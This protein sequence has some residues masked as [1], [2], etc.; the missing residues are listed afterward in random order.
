MVI[1]LL[2]FYTIIRR[3]ERQTDA[4]NTEYRKTGSKGN[5]KLEEMSNL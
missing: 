4:R 3:N 5:N 2:A 1:M